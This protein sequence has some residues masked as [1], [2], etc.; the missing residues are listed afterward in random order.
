[1]TTETI[2]FS[3]RSAFRAAL[4]AVVRVAP[5]SVEVSANGMVLTRTAG[6]FIEDGF[7]V[8]DEVTI[9][10]FAA[11]GNNGKTQITDWSATTMT[12]AKA[13]EAES[14]TIS[15]SVCLPESRHWEGFAFQPVLG[16]PFVD[17]NFLIV[18]SNVASLGGGG[19]QRHVMSAV[20][21]LNYPQ[22]IG[23]RAIEL[24]AGRLCKVFEPGVSLSRDGDVGSVIRTGRSRLRHD[25]D[26]VSCDIV[27][28]IEAF[29][30]RGP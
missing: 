17:E 29:S 14:A 7:A 1:M 2:H 3:M 21:K 26:W 6:S 9:S 15:M 16:V 13:L 27:V 28:D 5:I 10:G 4:I 23:T 19:M 22:K 20:A 18:S 24:M 11:A 25:P 8:G 12:V 30:L